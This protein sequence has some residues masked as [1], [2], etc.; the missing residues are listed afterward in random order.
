MIA[1]LQIYIYSGYLNQQLFKLDYDVI[2]AST[3][4]FFEDIML[5]VIN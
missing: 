5:K 1:I 2:E 4:E 3:L